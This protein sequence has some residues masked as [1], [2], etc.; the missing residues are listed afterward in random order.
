MC[1]CAIEVT[2]D[3]LRH[4]CVRSKRD[5]HP[6]SVTRLEQRRIRV[7]LADRLVQA[8]RGDFDAG[9]RRFDRVGGLLVEPPGRLRVGPRPMVPDEVRM[10]ERVEQPA[11]RR[12]SQPDEVAA[13]G[14]VRA[15]LLDEPGLLVDRKTVDVVDRAEQIIPRIRREQVRSLALPPGNVVDLEAELDGQPALLCPGDRTYVAVEVPRAPIEHVLLI[16]EVTRLLEVVDVLGEADL[17]DA[18]YNCRL[19]ES[20]HRLDRMVDPLLVIA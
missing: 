6:P 13:P 20:L 8:G 5:R 11:P 4:M 19:D 15:E 14:F 3:A 9:A 1:D 10:R 17:V 2:A 18:A 12:V 7:E 16:P